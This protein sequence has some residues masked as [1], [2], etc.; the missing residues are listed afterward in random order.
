MLSDPSSSQ[1]ITQLL[2]LAEQQFT[3]KLD[4]RT[5]E[6]RQW[7]LYWHLGRLVWANGGTHPQRRWQR[8]LRLY[9]PQINPQLQAPQQKEES[10]CR[11]YHLLTLLAK[12]KKINAEQIIAVIQGTLSEVFF[13]IFQT[14]E[15]KDKNQ[16]VEK[17]LPP[18]AQNLSLRSQASVRPANDAMLP[19]SCILELDPILMHTQKDWDNWEKVGLANLSPHLAPAI[20][21][22]SLLQKQTSPKVYQNLVKLIDGKSTLRDLAV[23]TKQDVLKLTR[24]LLPYIR[25]KLLGLVTIQD[26]IPVASKAK[27][28]QNTTPVN[29]VNS[30][31]NLIA[32]IDD[33]PQVSTIMKQI[34]QPA[35]YRVLTIQDPVQALPL[36]FQHKPDLVFLDLIMPI[37]NG[38]EI[39]TQ[40][41]RVSQFQNT[42]VIILSGRDGVVDRVRAKM[43]GATDFLSKPIEAEKVLGILKKYLSTQTSQ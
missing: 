23:V 1:L 26:I 40:I 3:G 31:S 9:C 42:P 29:K 6:I 34:L 22:K 24:S 21:D 27:A 10:E 28:A 43:S 38:Y 30:S 15:I 39:C 19:P 37:A 11:D 36:L 2:N 13:D 4:I 35:G 32:C 25:Q 12:H 17:K 18:T 8:Q 14:L 41:R 33:S 20:K 5:S 7:S 16:G